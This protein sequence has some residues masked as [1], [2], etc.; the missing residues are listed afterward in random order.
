MD[1]YTGKK[2]DGRY[3]I[4]ELIGV[5][6]MANVYHCY[7]TIDAREVAIK[8]LKDEFL[9]NEDF[10]RRF[11]NESKA[12]AV[13][14]HP[15][16]VRVYDVSF[17]DMIQYIV[18][19]YIDGITLKEYIDMQKVLDWKET[20]HLT[21]Q[22]LKALQHAHENGIVHR[23]IKPHNIMLLQDGTIKVTDFGIA[24]FSSNAT[25]TMT[26]QAIGSVHY[27]APEQA[28]GEK[29]DGKTDIYSVGVMMYEMLTGTLP[30]DGDSAVTVALMQLQAKAKRPREIN[31]DI[32]EGLEEITMKAM[33]KDP[34]DRY[35]S[36]VE[37]LSDIERF[38]LNPSILFHYTYHTDP[39]PP[40]DVPEEDSKKDYEDP[41]A[42]AEEVYYDE[43]VPVR[44]PVLSAIKG[45]ILAAVIALVV[46]GGVAA[47]QGYISAQPKE[48]EVPDFTNMTLSEANA[49]NNGK[50]N[51]SYISRYSD[52][53]P[54]DTIIEQ[55]PA[56][57]SKKMKEGSTIE[58]VVNSADTY[59]AVPYING[60]LGTEQIQA[61]IE[62][63]NLVPKILYVE[64]EQTAQKIDGIYPPTGTQVKIGSPV[65]VYVSK[66]VTKPRFVMPDIKGYS[67]E[68][69]VAALK[70]AGFTNCNV[71]YDDRIEAEKD[72]VVRQN[73]MQ[74]SEV[75]SDYEIT[76]ICSKGSQKEK[77]VNI[78]VDLPSEVTTSVSMKVL[79]DGAVDND[80]SKDVVPSYSPKYKIT[81]K[82]KDDAT[83]VVLLDDQQ[84]REYKVDYANNSVS[85]ANSYPYTP[86]ST[87][88]PAT[89]APAADE[90]E[91]TPSNQEE[92]GGLTTG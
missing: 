73:P 79:V 89:Q 46:F 34:E 21:T 62:K 31:P 16:I 1:K 58:L 33:Q 11:K 4:R 77:K 18:M 38:R 87:D 51:F 10:I 29:T 24:R 83:I 13:L 26:E 14:N 5:G 23:D 22:I 52:D 85:L 8:I 30:F 6:G 25:R 65:Y 67:A 40:E 17:G 81:V 59:I 86:K 63:A 9:D 60:A 3:E 44:S 2:L 88:A 43:D 53:I 84:Y 80:N 82:V 76:V 50:F 69:A 15:N 35:H 54:V 91:E 74:G 56:G 42:D 12:I 28:R 92:V 72:E 36:A 19:E 45:I 70:E 68:K 7:D 75:P 71:E 61:T 78:E 32:P 47:Y 55:S 48:I 27:I 39:A 41:E 57:G 20:V 64:S 49:K 66:G 37:M 90:P